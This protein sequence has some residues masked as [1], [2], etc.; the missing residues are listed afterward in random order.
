MND[1]DYDE[2]EASRDE[3]GN[4]T[5]NNQDGLTESQILKAGEIF[6][7]VDFRE[8]NEKDASQ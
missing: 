7:G 3:Y 2:R 6:E 1:I 8:S 5:A 4:V